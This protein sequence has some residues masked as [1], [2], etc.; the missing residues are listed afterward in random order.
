MKKIPLFE[1]KKIV[2]IIGSSAI[3]T[4]KDPPVSVPFSQRV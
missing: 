3:F 1:K 2:M 4:L